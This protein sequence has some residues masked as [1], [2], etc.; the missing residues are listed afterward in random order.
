MN[1]TYLRH[2]DEIE[3]PAL[4]LVIEKD[5]NLATASI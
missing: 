1:G 3:R 5:S 4:V 2:A